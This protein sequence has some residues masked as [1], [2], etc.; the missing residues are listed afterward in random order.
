MSDIFG[1]AN[2]ISGQLSAYRMIDGMREARARRV[3]E[4]EV[5][6]FQACNQWL[7]EAL[8]REIAERNRVI[9]AANAR[10]ADYQRQIAQLNERITEVEQY[11]ARV[12][13]RCSVVVNKYNQ[14]LAEYKALRGDTDDSDAG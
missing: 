1:A 7:N 11:S 5:A 9:N 6:Y 10:E 3:Y 8:D 4:S 12:G 14:L 13:N 2:M